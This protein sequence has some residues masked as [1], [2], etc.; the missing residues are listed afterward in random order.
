[1]GMKHRTCK[2]AGMAFLAATL[3]GCSNALT[4][5]DFAGTYQLRTI[6]GDPL[7]VVIFESGSASHVVTRE[8]L[9]IDGAAAVFTRDLEERTATSVRPYTLTNTYRVE[10]DG[11]HLVLF[12]I[13]PINALCAAGA[14]AP[15]FAYREPGGQIRVEGRTTIGPMHFD[16]ARMPPLLAP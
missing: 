6:A 1:M 15:V 3:A 12:Y 16:P 8:V 7:P 9:E 14:P 13:C 2:F 10:V 4:P 11:D 5:G